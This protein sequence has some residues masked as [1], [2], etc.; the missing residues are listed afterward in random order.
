MIE[1]ALYTSSSRLIWNALNSRARNGHFL[2]DRSYMDYHA[3]RFV[4]SSLIFSQEGSQLALLPANIVGDTFYSHQ[5]LTFGGLILD[6]AA[7]SI[8][9]L[10]MFEALQAHLRD[11][12]IRRIIYKCMPFIYH[13][14]PAQED[15]Y[16]LFR[17]NARVIRRDVTTAID[18]AEPIEYSKRR[19]RGIKKAARAGVSFGQSENW[20]DFWELLT[21]TLTSRHGVGP[22][23]TLEEITRLAAHFQESIRL[24]VSIINGRIIA[25]VVMYETATVAH[26]QY[27]AANEEGR[28]TGA[29]DGLFDFLIS[30]Y[31]GAR[32]FFDFGISNVDDGRVLN[33][34]LVAQKEEFGG[35]TVVHE[36]YEMSLVTEPA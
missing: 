17:C 32:R 18:Y 7:N 4:D 5:G 2:F 28:Q 9:V 27:I 25:G 3:S 12:G 21:E 36:V 29:L 30:H 33:A 11:R 8:R 26:A 24:F 19:Q 14:R 31:N 10:G 23:H 6:E 35:S 20:R 1:I 15:L 13:Q 22:T 16:A 34:G